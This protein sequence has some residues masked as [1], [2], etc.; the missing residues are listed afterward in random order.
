M[1]A[2]IA[3]TSIGGGGA[4]EGAQ[5]PSPAVYCRFYNWLHRA[6]AHYSHTGAVRAHLSYLLC[7][8]D[9]GCPAS[10]SDVQ[11]LS[12]ERFVARSYT[13]LPWEPIM[14]RKRETAKAEVNN[15]DMT[16]NVETER[17][18]DNQARSERFPCSTVRETPL[19]YKVHR[20]TKRYNRGGGT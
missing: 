3:K 13:L 18:R 17:K 14:N 16:S 8:V 2:P 7:C 11:R 5:R 10:T 4:G 12:S 15:N 1:H 19:S 6:E 9:I 20:P